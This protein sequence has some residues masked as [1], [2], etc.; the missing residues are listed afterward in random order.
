MHFNKVNAFHQRQSWNFRVVPF[1]SVDCGTFL[2]WLMRAQKTLASKKRN[3]K[4]S[5]WFSLSTPAKASSTSNILLNLS[6]TI[7]MKFVAFL[8]VA[9]LALTA[10]NRVSWWVSVSQ[11]V[12]SLSRIHL[13]SLASNTNSWLR[14]QSLEC[15]NPYAELVHHEWLP[16]H[17][18]HNPSHTTAPFIY[19]T[20]RSIPF[21]YKFNR[22]Q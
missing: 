22:L 14:S 10:P 21:I 5:F 17:P 7:K 13:T 18:S 6:K 9:I 19:F 3:H 8:A 12:T 4:L 1:Q 16:R 2:L 15:R 20:W 11:N